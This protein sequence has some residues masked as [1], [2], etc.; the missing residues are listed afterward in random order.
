MQ[1]PRCRYVRTPHDTQPDWQCPGCGGAY[2]K[3]SPPDAPARTAPPAPEATPPRSLSDAAMVAGAL[4][5]L[6]LIGKGA[7]QG[8]SLING[9]MLFPFFITLTPAL[10]AAL[11]AGYYTWNKWTMRFEPLEGDPL[12]ARAATVFLGAAAVFFAWVF[13]FVDC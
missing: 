11:G 4:S 9:L 1:C 7:T 13:L 8:V 2:V 3:L 10:A 6:M 5:T 12:L